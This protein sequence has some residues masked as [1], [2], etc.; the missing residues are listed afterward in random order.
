M[1][2]FIT[3]VRLANDRSAVLGGRSTE[4]VHVTIRVR[5]GAAPD[6]YT[7]T[8]I[9]H[10]QGWA[11]DV[12]LPMTLTVTGGA[13][14]RGKSSSSKRS[15]V[16]DRSFGDHRRAAKVSA[17]DD[18]SRDARPAQAPASSNPATVTPEPGE[19]PDAVHDKRSGL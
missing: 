10:V 18:H 2:E 12:R 17:H 19:T 5:D 15:H 7:G 11:D 4:S 6:V 1:A 14:K 16:R 13:G 8:L 9:V 3:E